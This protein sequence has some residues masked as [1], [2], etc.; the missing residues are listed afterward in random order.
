MI[1]LY[2]ALPRAPNLLSPISQQTLVTSRSPLQDI[3]NSNLPPEQMKKSPPMEKAY[4]INR[5]DS[6][7]SGPPGPPQSL[8]NQKIFTEAQDTLQLYMD[9]RHIIQPLVLGKEIFAKRPKMN[10]R[11]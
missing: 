7:V 2:S 1:L 6:N 9:D 8:V 5:V 10:T 11:S 4:K 3:T